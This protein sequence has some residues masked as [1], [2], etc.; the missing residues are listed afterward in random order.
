MTTISKFDH[1]NRRVHLYLGLFL[2]PWLLMY[3]ISSFLISHHAWF[4]SDQQPAWQSL[5]E[6]EYQRPIPTQADLREVAHEILKDCN[7]EGAFWVE[8]PRPDELRIN[9]FRFWDETRLVYSISKQRLQAEHQS[10]RWDQVILRMHFRGGFLQPT[11]WDDLWAV[12]VDVACL[13][14]LAWVGS[15]LFMWW[16]LTRLRTWGTLAIGTGLLSFLWL[17]WWL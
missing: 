12:L 14:I 9:R 7:L 11:L 16:R 8:R 4:R 5:F 3:G 1:F 2:T 6:K 17:L 13:G 15:G 10:L